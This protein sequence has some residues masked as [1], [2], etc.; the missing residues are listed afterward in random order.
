M[1][2]N[3]VALTRALIGQSDTGEIERPPTRYVLVRLI[4]RPRDSLDHNSGCGGTA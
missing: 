3:R 4:D 1:S 2:S